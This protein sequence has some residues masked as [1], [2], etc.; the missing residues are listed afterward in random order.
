MNRRRFVNAA[1]ALSTLPLLPNAAAACHHTPL[2]LGA[3]PHYHRATDIALDSGWLDKA[4]E[5]WSVQRVRWEAADLCSR[6]RLIPGVFMGAPGRFV[7]GIILERDED[8]LEA[9]LATELREWHLPL[10]RILTLPADDPEGR[11]PVVVR[12][13]GGQALIEVP[14]LWETQIVRQFEQATQPGGGG[15]ET[16]LDTFNAA[17]MAMGELIRAED[18]LMADVLGMVANRLVDG[19]LI[20]TIGSIEC[21]MA[22]EN[23]A[24][25]RV[26]PA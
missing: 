16:S 19:R 24:A 6:E 5:A 23:L 15:R 9:R 11:I 14:R 21:T 22:G 25:T 2:L 18:Q 26:V 8:C 20:G 3:T 7:A 1:V 12:H 10:F 4:I 17:W 13:S